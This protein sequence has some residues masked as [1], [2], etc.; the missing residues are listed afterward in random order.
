MST[1]VLESGISITSVVCVKVA[2]IR[3]KYAN[4]KVWMADPM[5]VCIGR[6]GIVFIEDEVTG[7]RGRWPPSDSIWHNPFKKRGTAFKFVLR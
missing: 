6:R 7:E 3:P 2:D 1:D 4:L 5:N